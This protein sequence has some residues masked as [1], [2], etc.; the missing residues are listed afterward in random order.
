MGHGTPEQR[1]LVRRAIEEGHTEHF[2]EIM[3][4]VVST[5]AIEFTRMRAAQEA[6]AGRNALQALPDSE[7]RQALVEIAELSV[8]RDR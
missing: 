1:A 7:Y 2:D 8:S 5:G 4:A 6:A 3:A